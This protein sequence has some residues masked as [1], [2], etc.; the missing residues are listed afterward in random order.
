MAVSRYATFLIGVFAVMLGLAINFSGKWLSQSVT[1]VGTIFYMLG[2]A[3]L[4]AFLFAVLLQSG[5]LGRWQKVFKPVLFLP[6]VIPVMAAALTF[7][8]IFATN[9]GAVNQL[10]GL[11]VS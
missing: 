6:Q 1:E 5:S 3:T 7:R 9:T 11:S 4:P 8:I 2:A 10:F